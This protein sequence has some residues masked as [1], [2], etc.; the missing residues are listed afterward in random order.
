MA[1]MWANE[2]DG[3]SY[4]PCDIPFTFSFSTD[5]T[6]TEL[7]FDCF[8]L[9]VNMIWIYVTDIFGNVDSVLVEVDVQDNNDVEI[10]M[11]PRDCVTFPVDTTI[12][13]CIIDLWILSFQ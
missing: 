10:C 7:C 11:D 8:D 12:T 5:T 1:C 2:F 13:D 3:S 6:D 4:H 9:G